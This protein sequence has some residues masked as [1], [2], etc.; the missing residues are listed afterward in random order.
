M[1]RVVGKM[2][3]FLKIVRVISSLN[4]YWKGEVYGKPERLLEGRSFFLKNKSLLRVENVLK[5]L[6]ISFKVERLF[7][8]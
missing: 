7:D 5:G 8:V 2:K 6:R 3:I 1:L 4:G